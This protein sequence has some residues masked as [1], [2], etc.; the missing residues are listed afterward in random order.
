MHTVPVCV[1][2]LHVEWLYICLATCTMH[3]ACMFK[4]DDV[5]GTMHA[6]TC[7]HLVHVHAFLIEKAY[8]V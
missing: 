2:T 6:I 3:F 8:S 7:V 4:Q 5:Q 1:Y